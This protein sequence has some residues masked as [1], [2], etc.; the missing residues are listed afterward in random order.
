V[1]TA[2]LTPAASPVQI[3][4]ANNGVD[5]SSTHALLTVGSGRTLVG[6][7]AAPDHGAPQGGTVITLVWS[8]D[9]PL[10]AYTSQV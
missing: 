8:G 4:V 1:P 6:T 10:P 3:A 7:T 9:V 2:V 5:F